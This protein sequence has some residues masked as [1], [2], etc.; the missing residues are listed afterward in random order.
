M[1]TQQDYDLDHVRLTDRPLIVCDIDEVVLEFISP[2]A[3]FLR[4]QNHELLPRSFHLHGNIVSTL[5]GSFPEAAIVSAFLDAFF[6]AQDK[7]QMPAEQAVETLHRLAE[8]ADIVFLTAMSPRH[9]IVRRNLLD[10]F[11]LHFPMV[12]TEGP[13]GPVVTALHGA[14]SLPV[15]FI[16]DIERNLLSVREHVPDCLLLTMIANADFRALAPEP[17]AGIRAVAGWAEAFGLL[18]AHV[19]TDV[20]P[21]TD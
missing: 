2:F 15:A 12:A 3:A 17:C 10:R 16:D 18:Q 4:S 13:K 21:Q 14:R 1:A 6:A 19:C 5:D 8:D 20:R 7:W 9:R 11:D